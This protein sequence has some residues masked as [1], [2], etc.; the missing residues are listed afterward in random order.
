M[1][2]LMS[3]LH[4][5]SS[6]WSNQEGLL[7]VVW[8][9]CRL[10]QAAVSKSEVI[11]PILRLENVCKAFPGVQALDN[12]SLEVQRGKSGLARSKRSR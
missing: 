1:T 10:P 8:R 4:E 2:P 7:V 6:V 11:M 12:V 9:D 5:C 3:T